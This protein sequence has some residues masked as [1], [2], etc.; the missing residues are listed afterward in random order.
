MVGFITLRGSLSGSI[1]L[2][3]VGKSTR[4]VLKLREKPPHGG[5]TVYLIDGEDFASFRFSDDSDEFSGTALFSCVRAAVI[6]NPFGDFIA[7]GSIGAVR[8]DLQAVKA[9]IRAAAF[10]K[11]RNAMQRNRH[12]STQCTA[13]LQISGYSAE[14]SKHLSAA[15]SGRAGGTEPGK[16]GQKR[17]DM[18]PSEKKAIAPNSALPPN[19]L[20]SAKSPVTEGILGK[21]KELF[22][23]SG[24]S[25]A[26][27]NPAENSNPA[28]HRS[29]FD[30]DIGA[31]CENP[32]PQLFPN[33]YWKK[34]QNDRRLF[35]KARV[36]GVMYGI[37]AV[38]SASRRPPAGLCGN[39]RRVRSN[40]G[41]WF[42]L[43]I[44][45]E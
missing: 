3:T 38:P 29:D 37:V 22:A 19:G 12:D 7:E 10:S 40:S 14:N 34:R 27:G 6:A 9:R 32:F 15:V 2:T 28:V 18:R 20:Q 26:N 25:A 30:A 44:R 24:I 42:W 4:F 13:D 21:A 16:S 17:R 23:G 1:R 11:E 33:S 8:H 45:R 43:G 39:L 36:R 31:L 35:G 5:F 41:S